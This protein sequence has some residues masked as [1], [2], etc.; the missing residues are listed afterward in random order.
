MESATF[1]CALDDVANLGPCGSG[2]TGEKELRELPKGRR[3]FWVRGTDEAGNVG[4]YVPHLW[5]VGKWAAGFGVVVWERTLYENKRTEHNL[6][7]EPFSRRE[8]LDKMAAKLYD[9]S[10][11]TSHQLTYR[12]AQFK[13]GSHLS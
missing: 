5:T 13:P 1:E 12:K 8:G 3:V 7:L 4:T 6:K 9:V 10:S 2:T 11:L